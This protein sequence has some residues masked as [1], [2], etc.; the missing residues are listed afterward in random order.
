MR[1]PPA[2]FWPRH[3]K[4]GQDHLSLADQ[5]ERQRLTLWSFVGLGWLAW[6]F[7]AMTTL[8]AILTVRAFI[9]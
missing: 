4:K 5:D 9:A 7:A 1:E 2:R 6:I 8:L 3:W